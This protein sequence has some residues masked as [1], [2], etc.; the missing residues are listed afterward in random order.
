M[1]DRVKRKEASQAATRPAGRIADSS[2]KESVVLATFSNTLGTHDGYYR[3]LPGGTSEAKTIDNVRVRTITAVR[4]KEFFKKLL[5][6][7]FMSKAL[8]VR[9]VAAERYPYSRALTPCAA[10]GLSTAGKARAF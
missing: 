6:L 8:P 10:P 7:I 3:R 2:G 1:G 4:K 9:H 5:V